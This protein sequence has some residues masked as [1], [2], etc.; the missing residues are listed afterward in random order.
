[1]GF[2]GMPQIEFIGDSNSEIRVPSTST[3]IPTLYLPLSLANPDA[4]AE[5]MDHAIIGGQYFGK[6]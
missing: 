4:F 2:I 1:M 5:K 3:F 6:P